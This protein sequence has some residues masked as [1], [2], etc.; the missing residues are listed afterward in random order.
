M[1]TKLVNKFNVLSL[2]FLL[3]FFKNALSL[4]LDRLLPDSKENIISSRH[5][6]IE[7]LTR[8]YIYIKKKVYIFLSFSLVKNQ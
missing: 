1:Q 2:L 4:I 5:D 3:T 6:K 8:K 7:Y